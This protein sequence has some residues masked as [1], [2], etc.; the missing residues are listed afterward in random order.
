M[1]AALWGVHSASAADK[2]VG[3]D[4]FENGLTGWSEWG[5]T[6]AASGQLGSKHSG[7]F[8]AKITDTSPTI[9]YGLESAK[10]AVSPSK[11]YMIRAWA[12]IAIGSADLYI[13]F[14]D[15]SQA[16]I[17]TAYVTQNTPVNEV[18]VHESKRRFPGERRLRH[19]ARLLQLRQW[20]YAF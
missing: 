9:Q 15:S 11:K 10:I 16:Y 4:S 18:D 3:N 7:S 8:S 1:L 20:R 17:S 6:G 19:R 2:L 14:Y 12:Y 5:G 13:R